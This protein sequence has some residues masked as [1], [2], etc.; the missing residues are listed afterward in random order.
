MICALG[1]R[2]PLFE[3]DRH[4]V[5]GNASLIG[6]V[7]LKSR[8]SVWFNAVVRGDN[9]W[10][11]IGENS[12]VQDG[13]VLHTDPGIELTVGDNVTIGHHATLH[14]CDV[15]DG[16]LIGIGST[17][18]NH[19][20]IGRNCLVG[21]RSLV[22]EDK[23][24]PEGVLIMGSP[25]K[26]IRELTVDELEMLKYSAQIYVENAERYLNLLK[27]AGQLQENSNL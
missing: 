25:A 10:I 21:A 11:N 7:R 22:T 2:S 20:R 15:G 5:A 18:L 16:S 23:V 17:I 9:D 6:S 8:V 4:F 26:T 24:F 13:S 12:N 19:A 27:D 14:G 3:G 1:D